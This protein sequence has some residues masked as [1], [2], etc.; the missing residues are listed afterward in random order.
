LP[1][2]IE[3]ARFVQGV[4]MTAHRSV[5]PDADEELLLTAAVYRDERAIAAWRRWVAQPRP[6]ARRG[7][8]RLMPL[9]YRNLSALGVADRELEP[10]RAAYRTT[11]LRN[12]QH[13]RVLRDALSRLAAS[14]VA[15][16]VVKGAALAPL[17]YRD[18]GMRGM[19]DIDILVP[20]ESFHDGIAVFTTTAWSCSYQPLRHFDRRFGYAVEL[21]DGAVGKVDLHCHLLMPS[22]EHGADRPFWDASVPV[23]LHGVGTRTLSPGD[24]L[25][26]ACVHGLEWVDPPCVHWI[27]DALVIIERSGDAIDWDRLMCVAEKRGVLSSVAAALKFLATSFDAVIPNETLT[28]LAQ[29]RIAR[30]DR[31]HHDLRSRRRQGRPLLELAHHWSILR[32]GSGSASP[33]ETLRHLPAYLRYW[34]RGRLRHVPAAVA[35]KAALLVA[36]HLGLY[37]YPRL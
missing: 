21:V 15:S 1:D 19:G 13:V 25:L 18:L 33:L 5:W 29:V 2:D 12:Q 30:T 37:R 36:Y 34:T 7:P 9:V 20:E 22:C 3:H 27:A 23:T 35:I 17:F 14:G 32:R 26:H 11:W 31:R 24:H 8:E 16:I 10:F 28:R 6:S 4:A